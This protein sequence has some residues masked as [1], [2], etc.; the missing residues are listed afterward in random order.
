MLLTNCRIETVENGTISNGFLLIKNG[1]IQDFGSM[2]KCCYKDEEERSFKG[3][4]VYP[5]FVDAHSHIGLWEDGLQLEGADGNEDSDPV[6][7]QM[8]ALDGINPQDPAFVDA[9]RAGVTTVAVSPGSTNPIAGSIV[10]I[11]TFGV[12]VDKMVIKEPVG[13]KF[14]LGENPK[15]TYRDKDQAPITRMGIAALIREQLQKAVRYQKDLDS[16]DGQKGE[17]DNKSEAL[18]PLLQGKAKAFFHCH[19]TD[20]IFTSIRIA[21]EFSL[22]AVLIHATEGHLIADELKE[23]EA[24]VIAGPILCDRGKPELKEHSIKMP[25]KLI[26]A[27]VPVAICTDHPE[28]PQQYLPLSAGLALRGGLTKE[29]ALYAI[30]LQPA[31]LLG[32]A[33]RVGSIDIGKDAD[34]VIYP[35]DEDIFSVYSIP[36]AVFVKGEVVYENNSK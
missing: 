20:D 30:T 8:R 12:V 19:R 24:S 27:G 16:S 2:E 21:K 28:V 26:L 34:L 4:V 29:Q 5:G 23:A 36:E 25:A 33:D 1:K 22:D 35:E 10:A 13:I 15:S 31:K 14:S 6:T 11:K 7:P 17:Y 18:L 9:Y 32:I 3:K